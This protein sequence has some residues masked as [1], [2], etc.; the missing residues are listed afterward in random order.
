MNLPLFLMRKML[1]VLRLV[2]TWLSFLILFL[3]FVVF[4]WENEKLLK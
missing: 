3:L 2:A 1:V 4:F